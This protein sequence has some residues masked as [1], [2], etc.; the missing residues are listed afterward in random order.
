MLYDCVS[1]KTISHCC[2]DHRSYWSIFFPQEIAWRIAGRL[3]F[4]I[5][6]WLIANGANYTKDINVYLKRL[7][8]FALIT[9]IPY[10]LAFHLINPD[11]FSLNILFTLFLG[12]FCIKIIKEVSSQWQVVF[13]VIICVLAADLLQA[14]YGIIGVLSI[15]F[16]YLF[17]NQK[18]YLVLSQTA[19][20]I[21]PAAFISLW[22]VFS[23]LS[24][25]LLADVFYQ[26]FCLLS[27][28]FILL[29]NYKPGIKA[30]YFF[31][32]YYPLHLLVIYFLKLFRI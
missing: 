25:N 31:Y 12:L 3:A 15:I 24:H 30:K 28:I 14:S 22:P 13:L 18:K 17:F 6:A 1:I 19:L 29:Y 7:L 26:S 11:F 10:W 21:L 9:Q 2:Y 4:P 32:I 23:P 20:F 5:F 16:F 27:L 8:F